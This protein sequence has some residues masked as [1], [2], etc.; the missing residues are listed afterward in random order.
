M[1]SPRLYETNMSPRRLRIRITCLQPI[2]NELVSGSLERD[3]YE[4][5]SSFWWSLEDVQI[6]SA[7]DKEAA[8]QTRTLLS[9]ERWSSA[10]CYLDVLY[11]YNVSAL[12]AIADGQLHAAR[13]S[14]ERQCFLTQVMSISP[15]LARWKLDPDAAE[16]LNRYYIFNLAL[17]LELYTRLARVAET[18]A[19][20]QSL[21]KAAFTVHAEL[22]RVL[23]KYSAATVDMEICTQH[24]YLLSIC[25]RYAHNYAAAAECIEASLE[26]RPKD[27]RLQQQHV[28]LDILTNKNW[29]TQRRREKACEFRMYPIEQRDSDVIA[30]SNAKAWGIPVTASIKEQQDF[31]VTLVR[32][33]RKEKLLEPSS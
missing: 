28:I 19:R 7:T 17:D 25:H 2:E 13:H 26:V 18:D 8:N 5:L 3:L 10:E 4:T 6:G 33:M 14:A 12:L 11:A 21:V 24:N 30:A 32:E 23:D 1:F 27:R 22:D 9:S 29:S 15:Q 31:I 16:L 20:V